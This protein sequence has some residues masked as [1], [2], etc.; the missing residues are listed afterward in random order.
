[1]NIFIFLF[2][3]V[4]FTSGRLPLRQVFSVIKIRCKSVL[5][6]CRSDF[7]K[8]VFFFIFR[9]AS[10]VLV[11]Q[12]ALHSGL[13]QSLREVRSCWKVEPVRGAFLAV[14]GLNNI[15]L[16]FHFP[17][18]KAQMISL[19]MS[20]EVRPLKIKLSV[21]AKADFSRKLQKC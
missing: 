14:A 21:L 6:Q 5:F 13:L 18:R 15:I 8:D 3:F 4:Q 11:K 7:I 10:S 17:L 1:M 9:T 16:I 2:S 20:L 12:L 19:W